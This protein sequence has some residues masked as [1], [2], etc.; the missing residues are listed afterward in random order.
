VSRFLRA[1]ELPEPYFQPLSIRPL[2]LSAGNNQ[3]CPIQFLQAVLE[4]GAI[5]FKEDI[6]P[7]M[8]TVIRID[9]QDIL[10]IRSMMYLAK[11]QSVRNDRSTPLV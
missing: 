8:N 6:L 2:H 9:T 7:D 10:V 3:A 4:H 1:S 11:R 5:P